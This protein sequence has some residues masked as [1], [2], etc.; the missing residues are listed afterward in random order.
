M[1]KFLFI[2]SVYFKI[3]PTETLGANIKIKIENILGQAFRGCRL[4]W[5]F[6]WLPAKSA[7]FI[8]AALSCSQLSQIKSAPPLQS[9]LQGKRGREKEMR[10]LRYL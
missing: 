4:A 9:I 10:S 6:P 1:H 5:D 3:H 8:S 2:K 7:A